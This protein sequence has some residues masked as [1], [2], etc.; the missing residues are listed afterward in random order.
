MNEK[1]IRKMPRKILEKAV[2]LRDPLK[3]IFI[4][5]YAYGPASSSEI[6]E[7]TDHA[8]AYV[9]MRLNELV[10][11]GLVKRKHD[12]RKIKFEVIK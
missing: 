10:D 5:L 11:L 8:R 6:A 12:G 3:E 2:W 9:N 7:L 4:A 1:V